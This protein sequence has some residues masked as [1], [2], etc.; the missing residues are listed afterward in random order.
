MAALIIKNFYSSQVQSGTSCHKFSMTTLDL[1][2]GGGFASSCGIMGL[3]IIWS[4]IQLIF[5]HFLTTMVGICKICP[6]SFRHS[7]FQNQQKSYQMQKASTEIL[8]ITIANQNMTFCGVLNQFSLIQNEKC[9]QFLDK[10]WKF[11]TLCQV[12]LFKRLSVY[13]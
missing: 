1:K 9:S 7:C 13:P 12:L 2:H 8:V 3:K 11:R 5:D 6:N 10:N 4:Y